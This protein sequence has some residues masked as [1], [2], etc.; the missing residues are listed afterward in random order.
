MHFT[1]DQYIVGI[2]LIVMLIAGL[3]AGRGIKTMRDYA[4]ADKS[5]R[6]TVVTIALLATLFGG[7]STLGFSQRLHADGIIILITIIGFVF[8]YLFVAHYI[9]PNMSRFKNMI[10]VG[11]IMGDMYGHYGKII[12]G[13]S[14]F[15]FCTGLVAAQTLAMGYLLN[16]AF[17][18]ALIPAIVVS[19]SVIVIYSSFGGIRSV[20]MTDII[21]FGILIVAIP[22]MAHMAIHHVGGFSKLI[23]MVPAEKFII[24]GHPKFWQ[25]IVI[26]IIWSAFPSMLLGPPS[27][28]RM[29]M[30]KDTGVIKRMYQIGAVLEISFQGMVAL[31]GLTAIALFPEIE[32]GLALPTIM[33]EI[34][35]EIVKGIAI[36]GILAVI[37]SSADSFLNS[38]AILLV[39][40][41]I[42]P[43]AGDRKIPELK[44]AKVATFVIGIFAIFAAV[45][46]QNIIGLGVYA[47]A[48]W[49]PIVTIPMIFGIMGYKSCE[50]AFVI[51]AIVSIALY[52]LSM[53]FLPEDGKFFAP[54]FGV[55]GNAI[56]F[57]MLS[58]K[59][60]VAA[61]GNTKAL[62][63]KKRIID[64]WKKINSICILSVELA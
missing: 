29:L 2:Y 48:L 10:S 63:I 18:I 60:K 53:I 9:A 42:K 20:T 32:S 54:L 21:Q 25:Y 59:Y 14:G 34:L 3:I 22:L 40:D 62:N 12:T 33:N 7:S 64:I 24:W 45:F 39:H 31:L 61:Q 26:L 57:F 19:S 15:L 5:Y 41:V 36:A 13:F 1:P 27:I 38:G 55:V 35:P 43:L 52:V 37:M 16:G 44:L 49:G 50:R 28:Q 58:Y 47:I 46:T 11:D 17:G 56:S 23:T 30:A 6:G 8:S 51:S 4:V